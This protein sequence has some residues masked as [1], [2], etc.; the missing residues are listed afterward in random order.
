MDLPPL[1]HPPF[2]SAQGEADPR[3]K[4]K[5]YLADTSQRRLLIAL[6]RALFKPFMKMKVSGLQHFPKTG[7]V[8]VAANHV[9]NFDVFPMQFAIPRV[10]FFMGKAE[11]FKNL[12]MDILIRNLSGFPVN[13]GDKDQWAMSHAMKILKQG[14]TLGM[15]PEGKR[16]KGSGLSVAKTGT[17]RLAI[18]ANCPIVP[19]AVLGTDQF[20]KKF[21]HR[22]PVRI[23][24]LPSLHPKEGETPLAFTDRLMFT[25]AQALP[26]EMRGVYAEVPPGFDAN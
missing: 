8:I 20:F 21:P 2:D 11:L 19:L 25:L 12:I 6:A 16:S 26:G 10:I 7:P 14:Q 22:T 4:K 3:D 15:F 17:A 9:T 1:A 24:L 18:E 13:R 5:Y 23:S